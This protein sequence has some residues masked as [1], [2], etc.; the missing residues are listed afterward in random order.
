MSDLVFAAFAGIG[1]AATVAALLLW[2]GEIIRGW[3]HNRSDR[4]FW[5]GIEA[6]REGLRVRA[7]WFVED[8]ATYRLLV[9]LAANEPVAKARDRWRQ[10]RFRAGQIPPCCSPPPVI[11]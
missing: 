11:D 8:E 10:H 6:E 7:D 1:M 9:D 5:S 4:S 3:W 2:L